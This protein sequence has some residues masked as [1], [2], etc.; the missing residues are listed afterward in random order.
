MLLWVSI[1][2]LLIAFFLEIMPL[3]ILYSGPQLD[4][5]ALYTATAFSVKTKEAK[6]AS[7]A[8]FIILLIAYFLQGK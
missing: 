3:V 1:I 2:F 5:K 6:W 4:A 8:I 7:W